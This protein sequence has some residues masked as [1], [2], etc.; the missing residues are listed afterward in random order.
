MSER[1]RE[2]ATGKGGDQR[3]EQQRGETSA[4]QQGMGTIREAVS[5]KNFPSLY[6]DSFILPPPFFH[7]VKFG[8]LPIQTSCSFSL[9]V[10]Y[11]SRSFHPHFI[12]PNSIVMRQ[13][14][15]VDNW[16]CLSA[17]QEAGSAS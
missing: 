8:F 9:A 3:G 2:G 12:K 11:S 1:D 15:L 4:R 14:L 6:I 7:S 17:M 13:A 5:R 10:L 16:A